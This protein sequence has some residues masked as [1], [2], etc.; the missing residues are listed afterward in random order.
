VANNKDFIVKNSLRV[1]SDGFYDGVGALKIP[2]GT[3]NERPQEPV[4]G[5]I[6]FNSETGYFERYYDELFDSTAGWFKD[7]TD[8]AIEDRTETTNLLTSSTG[9]NTVLDSASGS[10]AG[11]LSAFDKQKIDTIEIGATGPDEPAELLA[12]L[13]TVGGSGSKLNADFLDGLNS[14]DFDLDRVTT[15]GNTTTNNL[16]IANL[17][18]SSEIDFNS[19]TRLS[20]ITASMSDDGILSFQGSQGQ[21]FSISDDLTGTIF[22]VNDISGIPSIEVDDDGT[23]RLAELTGNILIGTDEDN[24]TDKVQINGTLS[25]QNYTGDVTG[26]VFSDSST[27]LVDSVNSKINLENNDTD[28]LVEG[29]ENLYFTKAR[30]RRQ[31]RIM[32]LIFGS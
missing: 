30:A 27:I 8:L 1:G 4:Q 31:S 28:D 3:I 11:L 14:T 23:I 29:E 13:E 5:M 18:I 19:P 24:G 25:A 16:E 17:S 21:L 6:R 7:G 20:T 9:D 26:S 22:S 15:Y 12:K 32:A 10:F 2:S